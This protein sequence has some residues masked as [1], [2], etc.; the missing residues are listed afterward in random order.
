MQSNEDININR[1]PEL[2]LVSDTTHGREQRV[3]TDTTERE[4]QTPAP[5]DPFD[6]D[7]GIEYWLWNGVRLVP[8]WPDE[9]ERIRE[10]ERA[11]EEQFQAARRKRRAERRQRVLRPFSRLALALTRT[12]AS[13]PRLVWLHSATDATDAIQVR[14]GQ[15]GERQ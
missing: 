11:D 15:G 10:R 2:R 14:R 6:D 12:W 7:Q 3:D 13:R 4:A 5:P 9:I 8:A 1:P